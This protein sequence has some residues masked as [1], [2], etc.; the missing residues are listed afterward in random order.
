[1]SRGVTLQRLAHTKAP[2]NSHLFLMHAAVLNME[3]RLVLLATLFYL[4]Q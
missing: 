4:P 1:M 2:A 3:S